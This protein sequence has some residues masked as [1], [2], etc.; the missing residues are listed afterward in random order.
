MSVRK[1]SRNVFAVVPRRVGQR[2]T[3]YTPGRRSALYYARRTPLPRQRGYLRTGGFYGRY[4][5][6]GEL[7]FHDVDVDDAVVSSGGTI[8]NAGTINVIPQGVTEITRVGRKCT[9]KSIFWRYT[10]T[11]PEAVEVATPPSPDTVRVILYLDKQANGQTIAILDLLETADYQSFNN[12]A[13]SGRFRILMDKLHTLN[14]DTM[15][16]AGVA[17]H[18]TGQKQINGTF[19]KKCAIPIEFSDTS[20]AIGTIR[21]N[22]LAVLLIS[23]NSVGGFSSKFRLRFSDA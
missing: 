17:A 6:G 19:F 16:A 8:Q 9:I 12:L 18:S 15:S 14:Y 5:N 4:S 2:T 22:N 13:N 21:S 10:V 11:I 3:T 7:K 23:R 20:G 1:R